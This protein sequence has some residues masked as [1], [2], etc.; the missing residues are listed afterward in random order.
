MIEL[1]AQNATFRILL[2]LAVF[3]V[4]AGLSLLGLSYANRRLTVRDQLGRLTSGPALVPGQSESLRARES[5][6][7]WSQ[8]AAAVERAGLNLADTKNER[9]TALLKQAGFTSPSAT[10]IYTLVRLMLI[11]VLPLGYIVLA[12][13]SDEP[14]SFLKVYFIG[15]VLALVGLYLPNLYVRARADRRKEAIING[16]P[17]CLDLLLVCVESGLGLEAAMDRVG[18]EMVNS[19]P[20]VAELL[21]ITVLQLRAGSSRDEAFRKLAEESAVDEIRAFT[22]LIIQSDKLGTSVATTLRVYAAEMRER[23]QMRAE[24]KAHRLPVLISIPLVACMLPTMI[25]TLMLPA[26]VLMVRNIFPLM[27]GG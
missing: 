25:G 19:H 11:F 15:S 14:V 20:K 3:G 21:M 18:R 17:D 6:T 1:A 2:L 23:R 22:T 16:F 12:Y 8:L 13:S 27:S 4:V 26:A 9:L 5:K 24:E 7:A 10:R